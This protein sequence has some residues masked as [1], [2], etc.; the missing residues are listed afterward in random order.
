LLGK[1]FHAYS[2]NITSASGHAKSKAENLV[3]Q[4]HFQ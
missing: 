2:T 1:Q 4:E 3:K